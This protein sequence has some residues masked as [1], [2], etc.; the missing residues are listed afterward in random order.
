[1]AQK[2]PKLHW[3]QSSRGT[4]SDIHRIQ[5]PSFHRF[6]NE[7]QLPAQGIQVFL[8]LILP[9]GNGRRAEG[10]VQTYTGAKGNAHIQ[11]VSFFIIYILQDFPLPIGNGNGQGCFFLAGEIGLPHI[12]CGL[13]IAHPLLQQPHSQLYRTDSRKV[14]PGKAPSAFFSQQLVQYL[15]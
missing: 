8:N 13:G 6:C 1:M 9:S 2:P 5:I 12:L 14:S 7:I 10:A 11:T 3:L 15:F 4:P